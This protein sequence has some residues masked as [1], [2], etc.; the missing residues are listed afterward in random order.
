M[1]DH[2]IEEYSTE[3]Y[4]G[5]AR[6]IGVCRCGALWEAKDKKMR[7]LT[8]MLPCPGVDDRYTLYLEDETNTSKVSTELV[9]TGLTAAELLYTL[10]ELQKGAGT[11]NKVRQ[12]VRELDGAR[13]ERSVDGVLRKLAP[14][15]AWCGE[16]GHYEHECSEKEEHDAM[17]MAGSV[18]AAE[19]GDAAIGRLVVERDLLR[20]QLQMLQ[21][22]CHIVYQ[23]KT[24]GAYPFEHQPFAKKFMFDEILQKISEDTAKEKE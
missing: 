23:P 19:Q 21:E 16:S 3:M 11:T 10:G 2:Y 14:F 9:V 4:R 18:Y 22:H 8:S 1:S 5:H 24:V 15:C 6:V 17:E 20:K 12:I 13:M 7:Q